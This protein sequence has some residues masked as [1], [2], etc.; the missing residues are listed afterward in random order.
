MTKKVRMWS[1]GVAIALIAGFA[2]WQ[3]LSFRWHVACCVVQHK[4]ALG[5]QIGVDLVEQAMERDRVVVV[6]A[7]AS[8][9]VH[10]TWPMNYRLILRTGYRFETGT[11]HSAIACFVAEPSYPFWIHV[12]GL[13]PRSK[14]LLVLNADLGVR[15]SSKEK[16][17]EL[18]AG[19]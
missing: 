16:L 13:T 4:E 12:L 18:T 14:E 10:E 9:S 1:G 5:R 6:P 11:A 2:L 7:E 19:W 17:S 15:E 8:Y 3:Y